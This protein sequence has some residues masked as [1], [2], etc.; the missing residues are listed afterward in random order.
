MNHAAGCFYHAYNRTIAGRKLFP[1]PQ[2]Y[3]FLLK[4]IKAC[5]K[6]RPIALIAYC[7]MPT[8]Y[9]FLLLP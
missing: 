3:A 8:H 6:D 1:Q 2:N 4:R 9:H 7:L 5:L